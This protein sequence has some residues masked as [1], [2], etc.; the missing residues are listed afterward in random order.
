MESLK[1]VDWKL[2]KSDDKKDCWGLNGLMKEERANSLVWFGI[3]W[4]KFLHGISFADE[5]ETMENGEEHLVQ[6]FEQ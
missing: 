3:K 4:F 5:E 1:G 2:Y 6:L